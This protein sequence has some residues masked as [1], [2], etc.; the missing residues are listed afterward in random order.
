MADRY[1]V[2]GDAN[3]DG[4]AG[5]KWAATPTGAGGASVPTSADDTYFQVANLNPGGADSN[6]VWIGDKFVIGGR[7]GNIA[8]SPNGLNGSTWTIRTSAIF[9]F[10]RG[11]SW[12]GSILVAVAD[13]GNLQTSPDGITWTAR[14]SGT[15]N[16]LNSVVWNGSIF[17]AV[18]ASGTIIT[19]SD[20]TTWTTQTSGTANTLRGVAWGGSNFTAVGDT[21]TVIT[22]PDGTTWTTQTSGTTNVLYSVIYTGSSFI[23]VGNSGTIRTSP[24]GVTWTAQTSGTTQVL[25]NISSSPTLLV[26]NGASGTI[27]TSSNGTT[28]TS[29]TSGTTEALAG[30]AVWNGSIFLLVS[31]LASALAQRVLT[32]SDG[33]TWSSYAGSGGIC[34][35]ATGNTGAKSINC[36]G[37]TGTIAGSAAISV[38][39]SIT[40][41]AGMTYTRT[42][43]VTITGSGTITSAGKSLVG[44]S[45]S[46]TIN[47]GGGI[48]VGLGDAFSING[49]LTIS[50]GTFNTNNFNVS[51]SRISSTSGGSVRAVN[52]GSSTVT[53]TGGTGLNFN[54]EAN[55]TVNAGTSQINLTNANPSFDGGDFTY[56]N[57][58]FTSTSSGVRAIT[59]ANTFNNLSVTAP[60]AAG[61]AQVTFNSNQTIN[62]TLSTTGTAGNRR[63]WFSS[64][65]YGVRRTLTINSA[66]SLT[67]AE[68]RD[69]IVLGTSAP[70]SGTRIGNRGACTGITF[71]APKTV[72][73]NLAGTQNWSANGWATTSTGTPSTDNFPLPQ[74]TATFT[75]AGSAGTITFDTAIGYT[76]TVDMS[77][78]TT[79][80]TL[81][82]ASSGVIVYGSWINGSG[83][84]FT[85]GSGNGPTF[86]GEGSKTITSAGKFFPGR[87][88]INAYGGV[89]TLNDAIRANGS[90]SFGVFD[91]VNGTYDTAGYAH[92]SASISSTY[93]NVRAIYLRNSA[94]TC[95][96][97]Q[98]GVDF[99]DSTNLTF[100]AGT[101]SITFATEDGTIAG[102]NQTFY[103]V[104]FTS[105]AQ[106]T[107]VISGDNTF[108]NLSFTATSSSDLK[109]I[110]LTGNQTINGTLTASG[111]APSR[112]LYL[113]GG[114]T[115]QRTLT[116]NAWSASPA[117]IDFRGIN[118]AGSVGTLSGTRFG[119][120]GNNTNIT[121]D[122]PKTVYRVGSNTTW[123]GSSSWALSSGGAG[124]NDNFPLVQDTVVIDDNT[125]QAS[126]TFGIPNNIGSLDC[127]AKTTAITITFGSSNTIFGNITLGSGVTPSS[128]GAQFFSGITTQTFISAGKTITFPITVQQF[129]SSASFQLGDSLT[130]SSTITLTE[131]E[132]DAVTYNVTCATFSSSNTNSR[133]LKMGS[134]LWTI[135]GTGTT[136]WTINSSNLTFLKGTADILLE[137]T[138]T[139]A[140]TFAGG[141]LSYNKL[142]IGG[143][144]GTSTLT[145]TGNNQFTELASTKTVAHTIAL[146]TT[147]QTFGAWTVTGTVGN[148]VTLTG[149]GTGHILLGSATTGINYLAMGSIGFSN[150]STGE[151]Y[152]GANS[153]GTAVAPVFRTA[154][155]AP[156]TLYWV[157]GTGNWSSTARWSL[158]SGGS[159][160]EP[161]PRSMDNVIF[162]SASNATAYTATVDA[163]T[164]G[165]RCNQLT[166]AGPASGNVTLAG[167]NSL[168]I[169]GDVTLP[170]TGLTRT[171]TGAITLSGST[172]GKTFTT[173]GVT[174]S[175]IITVNGV[176]CEWT[177]GSALDISAQN[178]VVTNG[179]FDTGGY[180]ITAGGL[181]SVGANNRTIKLNASTVTL[182]QSTSLSFS[183]G[184]GNLNLNFDAGTSQINL[185]NTG[186]FVSTS[187]FPQ[188]FYNVSF[189]S[190]SLGAPSISGA[191]TFNNLTV[192][193]LA[194]AGIANL[195]ISANQTINGTLTLSAGASTSARTFVRSDTIGT[196]RTLTCNAVSA[197]YVD[198]RDIT[199]AGSAA[200][201]SGTRLGD[202]GGNSGITFPAAKTVYWNRPADGSWSTIAWADSPGGTVDS[203]NFPLAQDTVV[204]TSASPPSAGTV[205]INAAYNIGTL[206][207]SARTTNTMSLSFGTGGMTFHGDFING[208]GVTLS[209]NA[210]ANFSGRNTQTITF[211][212]NSFAGSFNINSPSGTVQ[213]ADA[214]NCNNT[215]TLTRGTFDA[216]TYNVTA[217][218]FDSNN[219]NTRVLNLGSS[220][221]TLSGTGIVWNLQNSNNL[222]FN[223]GTANILL[224]NT[225]TTSRTIQGG[226]LS[227][228]KLTI[229]GATGVSTTTIAGFNTFTELASTKTVAHTID[230]GS[231]TQRVGAFTVTGTAGNVVTITGTGSQ[232]IYTGAG[233]ITGL[234]YLSVQ[235]RAYGANGELVDIWYAGNNSV[236]SGSLG[237]VFAAG[238][239]PPPPVA[240]ANFFLLF[241]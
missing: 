215:L 78:R 205:T 31:P 115:T 194:G 71:D 10:I 86:S 149:T 142:T 35:I 103:N 220:L 65:T 120:C 155:P 98:S 141:G 95:T 9:N 189:T 26:A 146:G 212:G 21:G 151:F 5:T 111:A 131:G 129:V 40:L 234:D 139:S 160:G 53:V 137:N 2:G 79:A 54:P 39:G 140:R 180:N 101:S 27:L 96:W 188:T 153:T 224:S 192:T 119:D 49:T 91:V 128:T 169:H 184:S 50:L 41:D 185:T 112:R 105:T 83:T 80:M 7:F 211:A 30:N 225:T 73:W 8:T 167:S 202:C 173:N 102:G 118:I 232:L 123:A 183:G 75:N 182:T 138:S 12:N 117:D 206:D 209:A 177:L 195:S 32:S 133:T 114:A 28:W 24:D 181:S 162:N 237:W 104:S 84:A 218:V 152:A 72:Y 108:N 222:T 87:V 92:Q 229:G 22:S 11:F 239:P 125:T 186:S 48:T 34:T 154:T 25:F 179:T 67:D 156:R 61:V 226:S 36:T 235:G 1:W 76:G 6:G 216:G 145:I 200:P 136:T 66:P 197:T 230:L 172:T 134:G 210:T 223:K 17:V 130:S 196:T 13:S 240:N 38:A 4:T 59:N 43:D 127:S 16:N 99:T 150:T 208:T 161:V 74:D 3:W 165:N 81:S 221:W 214:L 147:T 163:I 148:V 159:G 82:F 236:N 29:R 113:R 124:S 55:L 175:N 14:T 217:S 63:V 42:G 132:F 121:F 69:I 106:S 93:S 19:S 157:G 56:Y 51:C 64:N 15:A 58:A 203:V 233:T 238:T 166:I 227:Y 52:L 23:T 60:S 201:V 88:T 116:V 46:F 70:I 174:L 164:G 193:G 77:G 143:A 18:G 100:D 90:G 107:T 199:I 110:S 45:N 231:T 228:N 20:G 68:F 122:A 44:V 97:T 204:F 109:I 62:G 178:L 190:T 135:T 89:V 85:A 176:G 144:T 198:F 168:F 187:P 219:A 37:F 33:T 191:N 171:Y 94:V 47:G 158:S 207:M 213:L 241:A 126:L 170:A 57:V